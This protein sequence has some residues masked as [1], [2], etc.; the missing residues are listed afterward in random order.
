MRDS[1]KSRLTEI[2]MITVIG[3][4]VSFLNTLWLRDSMVKEVERIAKENET[5]ILKK[6]NVI[7]ISDKLNSR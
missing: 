3:A 6:S 2:I 4:I 1:R 7:N 5:N